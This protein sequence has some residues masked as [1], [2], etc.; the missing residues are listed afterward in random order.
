MKA[1]KKKL[2]CARQ[3]YQDQDPNHGKVEINQVTFA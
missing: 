1:E 2:I 3:H